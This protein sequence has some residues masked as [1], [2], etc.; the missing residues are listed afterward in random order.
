VQEP[1]F[2]WFPPNRRSRAIAA[3][4]PLPW[5][6]DNLQARGQSG[7]ATVSGAGPGGSLLN[8]RNRIRNGGSSSPARGAHWAQK[9]LVA[10]F[11]AMQAGQR[12][13]AP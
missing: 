3:R 1:A 6:H 13:G 11:S 8:K 12:I 4:Q 2:T 10:V 7:A 9:R 5:R